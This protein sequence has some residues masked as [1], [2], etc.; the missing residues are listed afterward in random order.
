MIDHLKKQIVD[1]RFK[2]KILDKLSDY[3]V[4]SKDAY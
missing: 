2:N 1:G 4:D 3:Q